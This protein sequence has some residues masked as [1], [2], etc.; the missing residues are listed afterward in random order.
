MTKRLAAMTLC[1]LC[2]AAAFCGDIAMFENLGFNAGATAFAF[3]QY[4]LDAEAAN[5]YAEIYVIDVAGNRFVSNGVFS[6]TSDIPPTLGQDGRGALYSLLGQAQT[7][8]RSE[9]IDHLTTGRPV[10][11]LVDG[12]VP[13]DRLTFRDF[14]TN[15]RYNVLLIQS[16]RGSDENI[17]ASFHIELSLTSSDDSVRTY[18]VGRPDYYRD[19]VSAYC[20][21]QILVGPRSDAIVFVVQKRM[22]DGSVRYMVETLS[23]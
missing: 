10:Y 20:I 2:A 4:G 15:T 23:I 3:G 8:L 19:Q 18:T 1:A 7:I 21:T 12:D 14:N 13:R 17:S 16:S 22:S 6:L 11:I 5:P 9:R